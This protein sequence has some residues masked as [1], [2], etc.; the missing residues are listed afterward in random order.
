MQK[1]IKIGVLGAGTVGSGVIKVLEMNQPQITERVGARLEVKQVLVRDCSKVRPFL[2][3][4]KVTDKIED[5]LQDEEIQIV[6]E[7]MGGLKP[8]KEY[9][10]RAMEA[11]K[12]VVTANKDVVAQFGKEMFAK[13][14]EKNVDFLFE[15]SVGGGI[16]IITPLKQCLTANKVTEIMGI[17]NGTTNYMLTKMTECGSDYDS[18]LKEA[19]EKGYAEANP[20]ADV[21]GLDAARKAAI[22]ASLAFNTR[23]E[24]KDVSVEGITKI[25]PDDIEYAKNLGY[26]IK[27]LAVGKDT[28]EF[29]VDVRV[30]PVF[31]PKDHPLAAVNGVFNAIFVRGN[32]IGDAMFYGQGAGS[33]PTA[34]AVVADIIDVSR[35]ILHDNFGRV[36]CTC[37]EDKPIC[38]IE[39]TKS[40][41]YVRLL[42]DD[43]PGVLGYV[44]TAFG[45]AGVSLESVIQTHRNI[46]DHA[47]IVAISHRVEHAQI[48]AALAALKALPVVDEIRSVIRVEQERG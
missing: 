45:N 15:A 43:K 34:S 11:G 42:V 41:Y 5:I 20:S 22:L 37:Y 1:V 6:V 44:A 29:G 12:S 40:S 9:M 39:K 33:L 21:D 36:R 47:E 2:E 19:Q 18:V 26:V 13:A 27:L 48:E 38:P 35:D 10:L 14:E 30:H 32:A 16:P 31:L 8:A 4:I 24:L 7:L 28:A 25:T 3:G 23:V 46:V 17:V